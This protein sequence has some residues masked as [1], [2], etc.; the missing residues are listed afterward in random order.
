MESAR[1]TLP[2]TLSF[3][4][5]LATALSLPATVAAAGHGHHRHHRLAHVHTRK[6]AGA[7]RVRTSMT[8]V[9]PS[10]SSTVS[11]TIGWQVTVSGETPTRVDFAVDGAYKGSDSLGPLHVRSG[12]DTTALGDG[13]HTLSATAYLRKSK[14]ATTWVTVNVDNVPDQTETTPPA[15]EPAPTTEEPAPAPNRR[16]NP[17]RNPNRPPRPHPP[18]RPPRSTGVPGSATS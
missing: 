1:F 3:L 9:S 15:E 2:R 13:S 17:N 11:G 5:A 7:S 16:R 14:L 18:R 6:L 8:T 4:L 10:N 12:L